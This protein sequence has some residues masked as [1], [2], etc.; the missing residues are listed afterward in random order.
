[1]GANKKHDPNLTFLSFEIF[2][3]MKKKLLVFFQEVDKLTLAYTGC[4]NR[5]TIP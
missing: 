5:L 3:E 2:L 4:Q 1:M